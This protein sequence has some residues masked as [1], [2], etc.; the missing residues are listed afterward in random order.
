MV[1]YNPS[2]NVLQ[3]VKSLQ[4]QNVFVIIVDNNS[5]SFD[6]TSLSNSDF[7]RVLIL[8]SNEGI[9]SAQNKG[10]NL[11]VKSGANN[12]IFF[13][14]DSTIPE[15]Y[16]E[17]LISDYEFLLSNNKKVAAIG[18]R[19]IDERYDFFYPALKL[20]KYGL[21]SKFDVSTISEPKEVSVLISSGTLI[22]VDVLNI[23]G[24]MREEFFIDFVDTEWCFR[25]LNK[26][27]KNY[28][29]SKSVMR[30]SIGDDVIKFWGFN[31]PVHSAFRRYFRVRN[32]FFMLQM[33]YIPKILTLKLMISN[34]FHQILL[35][36]LKK[37]KI[38]YFNYYLKAI[39]D[40]IKQG[41]SYNV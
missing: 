12:I 26:G 17:N 25:A 28:V 9:A 13:D 4:K 2:L 37:N 23:V 11:A 6:F 27:F 24:L 15:D 3:L 5:D 34:F 31:I 19:F 16:V 38:D 35:I 21:I 14:Q 40:G 41:R 30:H 8:N 39:K 29:S 18:P 7:C 36:I 20:N 32:L 10:V 22:P 1:T 33:P